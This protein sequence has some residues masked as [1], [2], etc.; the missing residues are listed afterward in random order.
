MATHSPLPPC[1]M[2][3]ISGS[4]IVDTA[5]KTVVLKGAAIGGMLSM[6]N[7]ITG[8]A[9][10]EHEHR[11]QMASVL[12]KDKAQF[13]FDRLLHHCFTDDDATLFAS[14]GLNTIRIPFNYRH[15]MDDLEP[16]VF[17]PEGLKWLDRCV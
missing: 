6:V 12:G 16:S 17:K 2:L 1:T 7:F 5:S 4:R 3:R 8:Y 15:F 10:H 9:G 13:F 14:L 11:A